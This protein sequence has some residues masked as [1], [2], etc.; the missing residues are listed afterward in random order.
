MAFEDRRQPEIASTTIVVGAGVQLA[1]LG[2]F[3]VIVAGAI[4]FG[5]PANGAFG[6]QGIGAAGLLLGTIMFAC[7]SF[8]VRFGL[9]TIIGRWRAGA[10]AARQLHERLEYHRAIRTSALPERNED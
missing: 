2:L 10:E 7:A 3:A 1:V 5:F 9:K 6:P 8:A 4:A